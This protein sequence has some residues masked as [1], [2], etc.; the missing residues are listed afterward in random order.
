MIKMRLL[1]FLSL[2]LV[3]VAVIVAVLALRPS[4]ILKPSSA[5]P[6]AA[7]VSSTPAV[8]GASSVY[9]NIGSSKQPVSGNSGSKVTSVNN[10]TYC[11]KVLGVDPTNLGPLSSKAAAV[12]SD[13]RG[14]S[15]GGKITFT[16]VESNCS[17]NLWLVEGSQ[18]HNFADYCGWKYS[19]ETP[20]N[21]VLNFTRW[22]SGVDGLDMTIDD[23]RSMIIN[24]ETGHFLG[25]PHANCPGPDQLS[26]VMHQQTISLNGCKP[27]PWPTSL[28]QKT[29]AFL[30]GLSLTQ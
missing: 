3:T 23:Y 20:G 29:L 16:K 6:P 26:P 5:A 21:V 9:Q 11:V 13:S 1:L 17:F 30:R 25:F 2:F 15:L 12:Y 18:M 10:I 28:E 7:S 19:C 22:S 27:N 8:S 24:H 4:Q 14:W